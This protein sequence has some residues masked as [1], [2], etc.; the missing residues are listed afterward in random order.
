MDILFTWC[1]II[2]TKYI[3]FVNDGIYWC[4]QLIYLCG[5]K[6]KIHPKKK[7]KATTTTFLTTSSTYM[8]SC[9]PQLMERFSFKEI[10]PYFYNH[11]ND[12]NDT[13]TIK[14]QKPIDSWFSFW[15]HCYN[16]YSNPQLWLKERRLSH[17]IELLIPLSV[18]ML[19]S[20]TCRGLE[21]FNK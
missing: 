13:T 14:Q 3:R 5:G 19:L 15:F 9:L 20:N 12:D 2:G 4:G 10:W 21:F 7:K 8:Y 16:H 17:R 6:S 18:W 1:S 11:D